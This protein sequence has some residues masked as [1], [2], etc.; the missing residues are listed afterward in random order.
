MSNLTEKNIMLSKNNFNSLN[1]NKKKLYTEYKNTY[2]LKTFYN[3]KN[4]KNII[5]KNKLNS[6][7]KNYYDIHQYKL[8]NDIQNKNHKF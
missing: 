6:S 5:N 8:K 3:L 2:I 1:K 7:I 4:L